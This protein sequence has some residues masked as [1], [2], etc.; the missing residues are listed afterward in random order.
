MPIQNVMLWTIVKKIKVVLSSILA[1]LMLF[2]LC[3]PAFADGDNAAEPE[4]IVDM[5][6]EKEAAIAASAA[7]AEAEA[8]KVN[9]VVDMDAKTTEDNIKDV[10]ATSIQSQE[11]NNVSGLS[12]PILALVVGVILIVLA[13][14]VVVAS[15][16][17][18]KAGKKARL[19]K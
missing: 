11:E 3:L 13:L 19:G 8:A 9:D 6:A 15:N 10:S 16:K 18:I 12:G 1:L 2:S 17:K 4:E 14:G 5:V 7:K